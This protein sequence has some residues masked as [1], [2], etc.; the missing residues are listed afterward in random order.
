[1]IQGAFSFKGL[2]RL[3]GNGDFDLAFVG[4]VARDGEHGVSNSHWLGIGSVA[5]N[6]HCWC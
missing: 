5:S 3:R 4:F 2:I 6:R 1:M